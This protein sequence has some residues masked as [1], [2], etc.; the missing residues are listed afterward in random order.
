MGDCFLE[1]IE[2]LKTSFNRPRLIHQANVKA[3]AVC[4]GGGKEL[5]RLYNILQQH[6][7][8]LR[9]M[10]HKLLTSFIRPLLN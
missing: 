9:A 10:G 4:E 1:P 5:R 3:P 6:F 2:C 7:R 8:A